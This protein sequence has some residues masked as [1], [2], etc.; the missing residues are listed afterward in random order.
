M[1]VERTAPAMNKGITTDITMD[2]GTLLRA[3][4]TIIVG[5]RDTTIMRE[6]CIMVAMPATTP[7]I[8]KEE[9]DITTTIKIIIRT[10]PSNF[11]KT[12]PN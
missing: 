4:R 3:K 9:R 2:T 11:G 8:A 1:I 5:L 7:D 6:A 10:N 12:A